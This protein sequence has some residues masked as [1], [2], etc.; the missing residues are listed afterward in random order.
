MKENVFARLGFLFLFL[1]LLLARY[2]ITAV[3]AKAQL[4]IIATM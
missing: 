3:I 2:N 4:I 1:A